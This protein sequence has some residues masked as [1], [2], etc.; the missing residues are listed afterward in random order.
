MSA[1]PLLSVVMPVHNGVAVLAETLPAVVA[2]TLP[3]DRWELIVV[4]DASSDDSAGLAARFADRVVE[5][6]DRPRG[7]S[8]ARN[9]GVEA[10][11]GEIVVFIDADVRV[12]PGALAAFAAVLA[13]HADVSAVFGAYDTAPVGAGFVSQYRNLLHHYVHLQNAG[14][15]ETFWAGCGAIRRSDFLEA[16]MFDEWHFGRPQIE[17]IELGHRMWHRGRRI[18][19]RP[20]IQATHL[21]RWTLWGMIRADFLDRG[22]PW[23]RLLI[24]RGDALGRGSL[25]VRRAEKL[26]TACVGLGVFFAIFAAVAANPWW[27]LASAAAM[28]PAVLGNLA[29]Y[30]WFARQRGVLFAIGVVPLQLLYYGLNGASAFWGFVI[31][32]TFGESAPPPAAQAMSELGLEHWPPAPRRPP[33]PAG[34]TGEKPR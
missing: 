17:D 15:A 28:L 31:H 25:N 16:G 14:D 34:G 11:R 6:P 18:L 24:Q 19:L 20:E 9:R 32:E 21:K 29:L 1:E 8:Y 3:R 4:D 7:P 30:R 5:L 22:L 26:K 2:S 13:K 23:M 27:L 33:N 12:H 10:A